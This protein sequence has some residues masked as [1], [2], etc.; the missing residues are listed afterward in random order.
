MMSSYFNTFHT[1]DNLKIRYGMWRC[2]PVVCRGSIVLLGGRSEFIEKYQETIEELIHRRYAVYTFDW[3]GQGMSDRQLANRHK[4][5]VNTF[6]DYLVDLSAFV[7]R[8]VE[9]EAVRPIIFLAHSMGAHLAL[10]YL[11][12]YPATIERA[13]L[14]SSLIDIAASGLNRELMKRVVRLATRTGFKESYA[15]RS[16]DFD[17]T[18]KKFE[19]NRIKAGLLLVNQLVK[20]NKYG[21]AVQAY[22]QTFGVELGIEAM[23]NLFT[24]KME[25]QSEE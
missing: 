17:P 12:E 15:T 4:G 18:K 22:K 10:R 21:E 11:H 16:K 9:P 7:T 6:D 2:D 19:N 24:I 5:F 23:K 20:A 14:T 3:R 1:Y 25:T 8:I 13:V